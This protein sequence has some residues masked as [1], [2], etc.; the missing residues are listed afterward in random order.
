MTWNKW[1]EINKLVQSSQ[2]RLS[3]DRA[4]LS[5]SAAVDGLGVVLE[6]SCLAEPELL[7]GELVK[8]GANQFKRIKEET[9]FHSYRSGEKSNKKIKLFGEWLL[10]EMRSNS[11]TT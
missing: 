3:F 1:F 11:K 4:A 8:I 6:S 7:K 9:R 5:I 10:N 2:P